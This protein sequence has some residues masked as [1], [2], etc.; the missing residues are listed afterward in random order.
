MEGVL[1]LPADVRFIP[2]KE[3]AE[4][5]RRKIG[6]TEEDIAVTRPRSR[7]PSKVIDADTYALLKEFEQ[8]TTIVRAVLHFSKER[9]LKAESVLD[10]AFPLLQSFYES[11]LLV[12]PESAEA[13]RIDASYAAGDVVGE[14]TVEAP[15]A[16]I[17]DTE[18]YRVR[19]G[20]GT[21]AVLKIARSDERQIRYLLQREAA[22]LEKADGSGVS[23][24]W[25]GKGEFDGKAYL[26][27]E[28]VG[29][30]DLAAAAAD[31]RNEG[32]E[33]ALRLAL[34]VMRSYARL[35]EAG[36]VHGDVHP[37][38]VK[39]DES[40]VRLLDFG[41]AVVEGAKDETGRA[42]RA[43]VG[44]FFEPEYAAAILG[45]GPVPRA[46]RAGEQ[47]AVAA[48]CY[49]V[50]A[51]EQYL[52]FPG[53]KQEMMEA[54]AGAA[55]VG[56]A[57]RK[58]VVPEQVERVL[59]R[60]LEKDAAD[61]FRSVKEMA[62]AFEEAM[63][64]GASLLRAHAPGTV[65][66]GKLR[67]V[68][69]ELETVRT[70]FVYRGPGSPSVSVTYGAA[71]IAYMLYRL[72]SVRGD[73]KLLALADRWAVESDEKA[74]A[75]HAFYH[76]EVQISE[77]T[78]GRISPYHTESGIAV[79]QG[80]IAAA[81]GDE[82]SLAMAV[83]RY[84]MSVQH[85]CEKIDLTLGQ[86]STVIGSSLLVEAMEDGALRQRVVREGF[87]HFGEAWARIEGLSRIEECAEEP[88][89][90]MA[91][92]WAGFLYAA[93][94]WAEASG[95]A[96]PA[97]LAGRLRELAALGEEN[98]KGMRWAYHRRGGKGTGYMAG[99]CNGAAGFAMLWTLAYRMFREEWM[100]RLAERAAVECA[101]TAGGVHSLC[102][103]SAG[104][105]YALLGMQ[106]MSGDRKWLDAARRKMMEGVRLSRGSKG[107]ELP[108]SLFKGDVGLA[109]LCGE[110][111]S[112]DVGMPFC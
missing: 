44:F 50:I 13:K 27:M 70:D 6:A 5:M 24:R 102:C 89:L 35:H 98:G 93:M 103:G 18:L 60:A 8:P 83:D 14:M 55:P 47:Y 77:E 111:D 82:A 19:R 7:T 32:P 42:P 90:G 9:K 10:E 31:A 53:E 104:Q 87:R 67:E 26:V 68:L 76:P 54:I 73:A 23:P 94:R 79:V 15:L 63:K 69:A 20:D 96:A 107:E 46:S 105:A 110:L 40:G 66:A 61:R 37:G 48:L 62:D 74:G 49:Y 101:G 71:G 58:A 109:L 75:R 85:R 16:L 51:G 12:D 92:G 28:H 81:M 78:V 41:V 17:A 86:M 21:E 4:E 30:R 25:M 72:A 100:G 1:V 43:G 56:L 95:T 2:A 84:L 88:Y 22:I 36:L 65:A 64:G 57:H 91:H 33:A 34:A 29:G 52:D 80:L 97:S 99:W 112:G 45:R 3:L 39:V 38:N 108:F 11:K 59:F 106:R